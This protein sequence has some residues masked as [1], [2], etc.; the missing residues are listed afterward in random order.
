MSTFL[1]LFAGSAVVSAEAK[2]RGFNTI[3]M[4]IDKKT[5]PDFCVNVLTWDY[6]K[7]LEQY[8]PIN[9]VWASPPCQQ[10]SKAKSQGVRDIEGANK[11]V[12]KTLEILDYLKPKIYIIENPATGLLTKQEFMLNLPY[13]DCDFCRYGKPFRKR[14]RLWNNASLSLQLCN[15][16]CGQMINNRHIGSAGCGGRGQGHSKSYSNRSYSVYE[17]QSIPQK[18]IESILDQL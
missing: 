12:L 7:D 1:E 10:Y 11:I 16:E 2:K 13:T 14:T 3:T 17:K 8:L 5:N 9:F 15:K 6:K 4:D 18:L